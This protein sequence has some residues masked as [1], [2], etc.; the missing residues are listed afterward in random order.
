MMYKFC[1]TFASTHT[2]FQLWDRNFDFHLRIGMY[3]PNSLAIILTLW[4]GICS[5]NFRRLWGDNYVQTSVV[6]WIINL[7]IYCRRFSFHNFTYVTEGVQCTL[8]TVSELIGFSVLIAEDI[9][10]A[11]IYPTLILPGASVFLLLWLYPILD[12]QATNE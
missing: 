7:Q 10:T 2:H 11:R 4:T 12:V 9:F 8:Y 3:V 6:C 5:A 1:T